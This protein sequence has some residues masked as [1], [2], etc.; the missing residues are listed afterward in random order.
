MAHDGKVVN[1]VV[2]RADRTAE[3]RFTTTGN[4]PSGKMVLW[5]SPRSFAGG[6]RLRK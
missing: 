5:S 3:R 4:A 1:N 2:L 6:D